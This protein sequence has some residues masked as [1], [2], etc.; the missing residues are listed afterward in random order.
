MTAIDAIVD[1]VM[2]G[3]TETLDRF[4]KELE[5]LRIRHRAE[6]ALRDELSPP[7]PIPEPVK[8]STLVL[9]PPGDIEWRV[10]GWM[11]VGTRG[12]SGAQYK[13]GKTTLNGN[14]MRALVDGEPFLGV[15]PVKPVDK[16]SLIDLEM[17]PASLVRWLDDIGIVNSERIDIYP[18]RGRVSAFA[19][20]NPAIRETWCRLLTGTNVLMLDPLRALMDALGLDENRETG[21]FLTAYDSLLA[22]AGIGESV[23]SHHW[24]HTGERSRGDSRLLDWPDWT[25][26]MARQDNDPASPRYIS[27]YGRDVEQPESLL[28][29]DAQTRRL[30]LVGGN[31]RDAAARAAL[32]DV[33]GVLADTKEPLSQTAVENALMGEGHGRAAVRAALRLGVKDN[34]IQVTEGPRRALLHALK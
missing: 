27:A 9:N 3:N 14:L 16:V 30:T 17:T 8:L 19:I 23:L 15:A 20:T 5:R 31:R 10:E 33:L 25:W 22:D 13:A 18:L 11:P 29:Y 34:R 2:S 24:G 32:D 21:L 1:D 6:Q 28:S 12:I 26:G 4:T 7:A